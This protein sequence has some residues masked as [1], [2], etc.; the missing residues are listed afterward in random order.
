[1]SQQLDC[2]KI[3]PEYIL[4]LSQAEIL[5]IRTLCNVLKD[6]SI[7]MNSTQST[8]VFYINKHNN[9]R[10]EF[11]SNNLNLYLIYFII[12][13]TYNRNIIINLNSLKKVDHRLIPD[14]MPCLIFNNTTE[15]SKFNFLNNV[16]TCLFLESN[17]FLETFLLSNESSNTLPI[18]D[19]GMFRHANDTHYINVLHLQSLLKIVTKHIRNINVV[20]NINEIKKQIVE[21]IKKIITTEVFTNNSTVYDLMYDFISSLSLI[22]IPKVMVMKESTNR[23]NAETFKIIDIK[24]IIIRVPSYLYIKNIEN[25]ITK[26]ND[27]DTENIIEILNYIP[28][29]IFKIDL[30]QKRPLEYPLTISKNKLLLRL[31]AVI[32]YNEESNKYNSYL[33]FKNSWV[34]Y[35]EILRYTVVYTL[36]E[37]MQEDIKQNSIMFFYTEY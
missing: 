27:A 26:Y 29:L 4:S 23:D 28:F 16:L 1:M 17:L 5:N 21:S 3:K 11:I 34:V 36:S 32:V 6:I 33:R 13:I 2:A 19:E 35:D 14:N 22:F 15:Y 25:C 37:V 31:H 8:D 9:A 18:P 7:E 20:R 12:N 24:D 10:Q 30:H